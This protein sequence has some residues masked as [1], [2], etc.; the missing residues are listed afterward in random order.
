MSSNED[1]NKKEGKKEFVTF[2]HTIYKN[3]LTIDQRQKKELN[4]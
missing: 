4:L 1:K 2:P 3:E